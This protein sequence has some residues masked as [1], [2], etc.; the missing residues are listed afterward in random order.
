MK[1]FLIL[2]LTPTSTPHAFLTLVRAMSIQ[3]RRPLRLPFEVFE[4]IE[5]PPM[6][7]EA[8]ARV[9]SSA[10]GTYTDDMGKTIRLTELVY[11]FRLLDEEGAL[12]RAEPQAAA[13][14]VDLPLWP[15]V[16]YPNEFQPVM[17]H[18]LRQPLSITFPSPDDGFMAVDIEQQGGD[19]V[20]FYHGT[21]AAAALHIVKC[22]GFLPGINGHSKGKRHY[23]GCF[24]ST[25]FDVAYIRGDPMRHLAPDGIYTLASCPAVLEL[26]AT[27]ASLV[28]YHRRLPHCFVLP[29][30]PHQLLPG[31]RVRA[32]WWNAR[33]V[34][35]YLKLTFSREIRAAVARK[36]GI[37]EA[38]CGGGRQ[39]T[40][41]QCCGKLVR[42][43]WDRADGFSV[44]GV[45]VGKYYLCPECAHQW[46]W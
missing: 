1:C 45:K 35:N 4:L 20:V 6:S 15:P 25:F 46:R 33:T 14:V 19:S 2:P 38:C 44:E 18:L 9:M 39:L 22:G 41:F 10:I 21:T 12:P 8:I 3:K 23:K 42:S 5:R 40:D 24:G 13:R 34:S 29:G 28:R 27:C 37:V 43:P 36:G 7:A 17:D 30:Q 11:G 32:V 31:L 26:E 16:K